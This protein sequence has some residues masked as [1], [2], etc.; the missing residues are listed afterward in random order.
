MS[1]TFEIQSDTAPNSQFYK[2]NRRSSY[3]HSDKIWSAFFKIN[4]T[5]QNIGQQIGQL[6]AD[7]LPPVINFCWQ[8]HKLCL[9]LFHIYFSIS[10]IWSWC[11]C[12]CCCCCWWWW[13]WSRAASRSQDGYGYKRKVLEK[14]PRKKGNGI[15]RKNN[16]A[17]AVGRSLASCAADSS[18]SARPTTG[19]V[20][21]H[22]K[23]AF[24]FPFPISNWIYF[25]IFV[26]IFSH[27]V[28]FWQIHWWWWW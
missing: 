22:F 26:L 5:L 20:V 14:E 2:K 24:Y 23:A 28:I 6:L 25:S 3:K 4:Q 11:C 9:D 7:V 13:L 19:Q 10:H 15:M 27:S 16:K 17:I 12:C 21:E 1:C 8:Y 18:A